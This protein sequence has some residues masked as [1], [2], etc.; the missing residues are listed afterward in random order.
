M[1][2]ILGALSVARDL[3]EHSVHI[4]LLIS[5]CMTISALEKYRPFYLCHPCSW[6][7]PKF[8][9]FQLF[10]TFL[11]RLGIVPTQ[12]QDQPILSSIF[13]QNVWA[14]APEIFSLLDTQTVFSLIC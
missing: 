9:M 6:T 3:T 2:V 11:F 14:S 5:F 8:S 12:E 4:S 7:Q 1:C 10:A 13:T